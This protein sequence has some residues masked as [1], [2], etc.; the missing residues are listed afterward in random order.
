MHL[1]HNKEI[2]VATV[3]NTAPPEIPEEDDVQGTNQNQVGQSEEKLDFLEQG[4][5]ES[6]VAQST[7][8]NTSGS[9]K[10]GDTLD[11]EYVQYGSEDDVS[12]GK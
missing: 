5:I 2:L 3:V 8:G 6:T 12:L 9:D 10:I 1:N 4:S 11:E 7:A